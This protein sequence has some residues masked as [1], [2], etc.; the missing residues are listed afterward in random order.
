MGAAVG[1]A[2]ATGDIVIRINERLRQLERRRKEAGEVFIVCSFDD[3]DMVTDEHGRRMTAAE[4]DRLHPD[5]TVIKLTWG[6]EGGN[7]TYPTA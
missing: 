7:E 5:A 2:R 6:D 4:F 1:R 3:R